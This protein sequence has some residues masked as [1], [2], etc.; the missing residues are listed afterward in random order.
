MGRILRLLVCCSIIWVNAA[1]AIDFTAERVVVKNG[2]RDKATL[3]CRADMWRIEHN[4]LG[5]VDVT[6]VRKDQGVIWLLM[7]HT[8]RFITLPFDPQIG[9]TC[10]HDFTS[11]GQRDLIGR[12]ILQ[13]RSTT[14]SKVTVREGTEDVTYYEWLAD[15]VKVPLRVAR[16][17][18][19]WLVDYGNLHVTRLPTHLFELPLSYIPV[20]VR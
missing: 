13:G 1:S 18:G 10:Q 11:A 20:D 4:T 5:P 3:Y 19:T 9:P 7:A 2:H 15:D 17:D 16:K 14:V 12:E 6:I 8:K